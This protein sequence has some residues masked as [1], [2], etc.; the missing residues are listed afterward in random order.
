MKGLPS[1]AV[2]FVGRLSVVKMNY[3]D[4]SWDFEAAKAIMDPGNHPPMT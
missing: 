1:L 4:V 3:S 2:R